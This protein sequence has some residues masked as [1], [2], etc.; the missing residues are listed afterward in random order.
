MAQLTSKA[1]ECSGFSDKLLVLQL[2]CF[3]K[4]SIWLHY[5]VLVS[6]FQRTF[7]DCLGWVNF[8]STWPFDVY[9][10]GKPT[11]PT[12][13]YLNKFSDSENAFVVFVG[14]QQTYQSGRSC[15]PI[16]C[17]SHRSFYQL[18]THT[19]SFRPRALLPMECLSIPIIILKSQGPNL[20][21][22]LP[23]F[24]FSDWPS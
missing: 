19:C 9:M 8:L 4:L 17:L 1:G 10:L 22:H 20:S 16:G 7:L 3:T 18:S 21:F 11:T 24:L 6:Y 15:S 5:S 2:G 13:R 23:S 12:I 14:P